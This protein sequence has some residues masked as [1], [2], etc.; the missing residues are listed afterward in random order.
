MIQNILLST[1]AAALLFS[2]NVLPAAELKFF[3]DLSGPNEAP[4]VASPGTGFAVVTYDTLTHVMRVQVSFADL[5]GT[6]TASHIHAPTAIPLAG[7]AGVATAVPTFPG[8]PLGVTSG[9]YDR[10]FDMTLASSYN[11]AFVTAQGGTPALAEAVLINSL[12]ADKAYLNIHTTF[13]R[14][15]EIRGFLHQAVP[16]ASATIGLLGAVMVAITVAR[17]RFS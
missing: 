6:T 7:T 15:G 12:L 17:K 10:S 9:A 3:A 1:A 11:P 5:V 4:P 8:F 16:D 13:A 14:G 2:A